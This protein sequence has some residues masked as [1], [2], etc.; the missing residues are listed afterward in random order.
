MRKRPVNRARKIFLR[1]VTGGHT[2]SHCEI[3]VAGGNANKEIAARLSLTEET[4]RAHVKNI[5]AK[6]AANDRTH[7]VTIGL[8]AMLASLEG[9][10]SISEIGVGSRSTKGVS[11]SATIEGVFLPRSRDDLQAAEAPQS[12]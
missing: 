8:K 5:L 11:S 6:L 4:V 1:V 7:A 10:G 9:S 2:F 12:V 3:M